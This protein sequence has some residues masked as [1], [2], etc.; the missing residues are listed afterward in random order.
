VNVEQLQKVRGGRGFFAALEQSD[1]STPKTL[2]LYGIG[3]DADS[4]DDEMFDLVQQ[5][6]ATIMRSPSCGG[7]RII[8]AILFENTMR[9]KV[10]GQPLHERPV[11]AALAPAPGWRAHGHRGRP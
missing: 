8:G 5:M 1:G 6:R 7:D 11:P 9:R 2:A 3:E 4:S 10:D